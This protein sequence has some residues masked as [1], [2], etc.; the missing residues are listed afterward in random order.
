[1]L[2]EQVETLP[3]PFVKVA[4]FITPQRQWNVPKLCQV[5]QDQTI[6]QKI[7]GIDILLSNLEDT[8]CWGLDKS[9]E[10]TPKSAT[11]LAH[12]IQ[13]LKKRSW[14]HKWI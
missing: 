14:P 6:V 11:W 12:K 13:P 1:L 8:L 7:R 3:Q 4:E 9:G 10:F 2:Q 5:I